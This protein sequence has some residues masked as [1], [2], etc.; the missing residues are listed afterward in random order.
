MGDHDIARRALISGRVQGVFFRAHVQK[1]AQAAGAAGWA[2][3][4]P[5]GSVEVHAE[6]PPEAVDAVLA[7]CHTGPRGAHV[8][9]VSVEPADV[10]GLQGFESR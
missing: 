1:A 10:E 6:G 9:E 4:R 2:A 3:N 7:A 8:E 5:D